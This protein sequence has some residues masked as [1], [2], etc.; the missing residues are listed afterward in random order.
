MSN[1]VYIRCDKCGH[2]GGCQ[3]RTAHEARFHVSNYGW[4]WTESEALGVQDFCESCS[5]EI[6]E[7]K[8][9]EEK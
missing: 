5:K 8:N 7:E 3:S 6:E 4:T 9:K 2:K 1:V